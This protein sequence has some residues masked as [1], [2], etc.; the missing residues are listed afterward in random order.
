M[1]YDSKTLIRYW[2]QKPLSRR[3]LLVAVV[4]LTFA[5]SAIGKAI[6]ATAPIANIILGR[7]T[8]NSIAVN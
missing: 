2:S 8:S 4:S 6:G 5:N 7:P 3:S 1:A